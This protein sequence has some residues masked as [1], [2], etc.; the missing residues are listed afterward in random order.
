MALK[1]SLIK[2]VNLNDYLYYSLWL[3][4]YLSFIF[5]AP[6]DTISRPLIH[7]DK[8]IKAKIFSLLIITIFFILNFYLN[9]QEFRNATIYALIFESIVINPLTY[10]V[11]KAPYNN[12]KSYQKKLV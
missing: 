5:F 7:K 9:S 8:R 1:L 11:C 10:K 3:F 12:Y 6:A 2:Y 4:G